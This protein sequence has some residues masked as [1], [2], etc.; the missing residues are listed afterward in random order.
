MVSYDAVEKGLDDAEELQ[1][2][3]WLGRCVMEGE[4]L[5]SRQQCL[6]SLCLSV[7][8]FLR[9]SLCVH[10][11]CLQVACDPLCAIAHPS[12]CS[13]APELSPTA[14]QGGWVFCTLCFLCGSAVQAA[15]AWGNIDTLDKRWTD[16]SRP[17]LTMIASRVLLS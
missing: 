4:E 15:A 1:C 10:D 13:H 2:A 7:A 9:V 16:V 12:E 3:R 14:C 17:A 5:C 6:I 11:T 8:P